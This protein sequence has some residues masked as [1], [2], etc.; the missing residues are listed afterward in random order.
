MCG[1]GGGVRVGMIADF[2]V[3]SA[4]TTNSIVARQRCRHRGELLLLWVATIALLLPAV[5]R[6]GV[7]VGV[8]ACFAC[9]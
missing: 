7:R 5:V 4:T 2:H 3:P 1:V 6:K 9:S 8:C